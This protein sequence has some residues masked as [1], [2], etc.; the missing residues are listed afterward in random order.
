L[1]IVHTTTVGAGAVIKLRPDPSG[2]PSK[3]KRGIRAVKAQERTSA[4]C[5]HTLQS[6][7][8]FM[9]VH[10]HLPTTA[11]WG[12]NVLDDLPSS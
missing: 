2:S 7:A 4:G 10:S 9:V 5:R 12:I 11:K 8:D 3:A 6:R 1:L